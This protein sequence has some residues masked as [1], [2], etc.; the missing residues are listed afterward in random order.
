MNFLFYYLKCEI[1]R[2]IFG[3]LLSPRIDMVERN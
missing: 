1:Q 3:G 2:S